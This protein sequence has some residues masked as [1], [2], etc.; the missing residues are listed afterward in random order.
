[1]LKPLLDRVIVKMKEVQDTTK[2]GII[3]SANSKEKPQIAEILEVGPG[4]LIDGNETKMYVKKGDN[5]V[6]SKYAGT[7]IKYNGE[8][9]LIV[10]Q[11]DILAIID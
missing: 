4:G 7:E 2:S 9:L 8:D 3:L 6:L 5:V 10:K 1:M 11:N